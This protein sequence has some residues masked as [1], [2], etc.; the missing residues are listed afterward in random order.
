M[1]VLAHDGSLYCDWVA[2]YALNFAEEE[3]DRKLLALHVLDGKA[4][5]ELVA[6]K[7]AELQ[8][9]CAGQNIEFIPQL[10]RMDNSVYRSLRHAIPH[11]PEALL[12]CGTRVKAKKRTFLRGSVAEQLLRN[13]QCPVLALRVV[14]PGLLGA[15]HNLLM[16]LA[17]HVAGFSR[18]WPIFQR[19]AVRLHRVHLF[20]SLYIH[21]LRHANLRPDRERELLKYGQTYLEKIAAE[22]EKAL[23]NQPFCIERQVMISSDWPNAVLIQASRLKVQM[24]LVGVSERSLAHRVFHGS[25]IERVLLEAPCDIGIYRGP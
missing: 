12:L 25:G 15:P 9:C 16:P 1:I 7:F 19:L 13:R 5:P 22:L 21:Q 4:S 6:N 20:R 24:T 17:G 18:V 11:D 8:E 23:H 10:L 2:R 14:Q 3:K